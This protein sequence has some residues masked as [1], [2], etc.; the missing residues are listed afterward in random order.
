MELFVNKNV[1]AFIE[2]LQKP[3]RGKWVRT[4]GLLKQYGATLGMPQARKLNGALSELRIRGREEVRAF[5]TIRED[6]IFVLHA[7]I[8]KTQ[9]IPQHELDLA[10][11]RLDALTEL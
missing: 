3:T 1:D 2:T 9:K 4:I 6:K 10:I 8:K 5:F 7:F 11:K